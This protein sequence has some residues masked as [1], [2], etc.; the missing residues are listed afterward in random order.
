MIFFVVVIIVWCLFILVLR[1]SFCDLLCSCGCRSSL[2]LISFLRDSHLWGALN[3][4]NIC[5]ERNYLR[6]Q[7]LLTIPKP[8]VLPIY[9]R[10]HT[11]HANN[12]KKVTCCW[13]RSF[14]RPCGVRV[15]IDTLDSFSSLWVDFHAV[16]INALSI[17]IMKLYIERN[18][19]QVEYDSVKN[20]DFIQVYFFEPMKST[21]LACLR[22]DSLYN[23]SLFDSN[24][25]IGDTFCT[26]SSHGKYFP[27][28]HVR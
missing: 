7:C 19:I 12:F 11:R 26:Q 9:T 4:K 8:N 24:H 27:D 3:G 16:R 20:I 13:V 23:I 10:Y 22:L 5:A 14:V 17:I 18:N 15:V 21:R 25:L 2:F 6:L 28:V 1:T